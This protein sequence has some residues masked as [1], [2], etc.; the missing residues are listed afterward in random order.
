MDDEIMRTIG[1]ISAGVA[2]LGL[3][4]YFFLG[5]L[6]PAFVVPVVLFC[7]VASLRLLFTKP[8]DVP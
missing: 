3:L 8:A 2:V 5:D 7:H 1:L 6:L 4:A